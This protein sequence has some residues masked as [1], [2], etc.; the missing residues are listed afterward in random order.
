MATHEES[1]DAEDREEL[2][3]ANLGDDEEDNEPELDA[4]LALAQMDA[5]AAAAYEMAAELVGEEHIAKTLRQF[6]GDHQR[7]VR[8]IG[9]LLS[10]QGVELD[11][12]PEAAS[13]TFVTMAASI[14]MLGVAATLRAMI[15]NE[16]FTNSAYET[17]QDLIL[18]PEAQELLRQ[19]FADEQR[20]LEWLVRELARNREARAEAEGESAHT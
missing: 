12:A 15:A 18:A 19:N 14:S 8:D 5:E 20:H 10:K 7:H 2:E 6:G 13:S 3:S 11:L 17:A 4:L 16:Q 9:R 1:S